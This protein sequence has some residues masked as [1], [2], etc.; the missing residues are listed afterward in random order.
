LHRFFLVAESLPE[1]FGFFSPAPHK[2]PVGGFSFPLLT[3]RAKKDV[4]FFPPLSPSPPPFMF[5]PWPN[6]DRT[7][8]FFLFPLCLVPFSLILWKKI[9]G[10]FAWSLTLP[11]L[12][13]VVKGAGGLFF[14]T[15][16]P[17]GLRA[18]RLGEKEFP[19]FFLVFFLVSKSG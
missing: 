1:F 7:N 3:S 16:L 6:L 17:F 10:L 5:G 18:L 15:F 12:Q 4:F 2:E 11:P 19:L 13:R 14:F 8:L 9:E